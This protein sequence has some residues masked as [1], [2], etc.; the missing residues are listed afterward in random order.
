[1]KLSIPMH[2]QYT[3]NFISASQ[4]A[5]IFGDLKFDPSPLIRTRT[6]NFPPVEQPPPDLPTALSLMSCFSALARI[7]RAMFLRIG[8]TLSLAQ[9]ASSIELGA[10]LQSIDL[11]G[12]GFDQHPDLRVRLLLQVSTDMLRKVERTMERVMVREDHSRDCGTRLRKLFMICVQELAGENAEDS[13]SRVVMGMTSRREF[14]EVWRL[15]D[16]VTARVEAR[17]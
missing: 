12:F 16:A 2:A 7:Y 4:D 6:P 17:N 5:T 14:A 9:S 15:F 3:S 1:M 8:A 13:E 11:D 10:V